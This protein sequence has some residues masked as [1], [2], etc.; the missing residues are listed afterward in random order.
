M[1]TTEHASWDGAFDEGYDALDVDEEQANPAQGEGEAIEAAELQPVADAEGPDANERIAD[2]LGRMSTRRK[3]LLGIVGLCREPVESEALMPQVEGLQANNQSV[4]SAATLV[5]LLEGAGA[6]RRVDAEG[7]DFVAPKDRGDEDAATE[8]GEPAEA[9]TDGQ[10]AEGGVEYLEPA[11]AASFFWLATPEGLAAVEDD[12]PRARL[13]K[14][15][16]D[17]TFYLPVY[18]EILEALADGP[19]TKPQLDVMVK[20]HPLTQDRQHLTGYFL[21]RLERADAIAWTNPWTI[22]DLGRSL[23][24]DEALYQ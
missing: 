24:D 9:P 19:L 21:D 22:T 16:E 23:L 14:L 3:V 18:R 12:D 17:D 20:A 13:Q 1:E 10:E 4:F 11:V 6:L 2:L 15:V 7:N 5:G 8:P